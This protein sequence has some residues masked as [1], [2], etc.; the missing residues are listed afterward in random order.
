MELFI[1]RITK[2]YGK[3]LAVDRFSIKLHRGVYGL[4]GPNG[5]GKTTLMRIMADILRPTS[6]EITLDGVDIA[7]LDEEYRNLLGYLP[8]NFGYYRDFTATDFLMY[9][10]CVKGIDKKQAKQKSAE[11]LVRGRR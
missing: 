7:R 5:S 6:G 3:K 11:L 9:L 4:L 1:D 10:A 8:Q 2:Q